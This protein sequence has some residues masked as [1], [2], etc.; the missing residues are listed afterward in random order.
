MSPPTSAMTI[1]DKADRLVRLGGFTVGERDCRLNTNYAGKY[2]VVEGHEEDELPT[3]DGSNGPWCIVG[4][5]LDA[6]VGQAFDVWCDDYNLD[7]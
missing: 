1:A 4:D 6:L 7:A 2:M 3:K 5:D